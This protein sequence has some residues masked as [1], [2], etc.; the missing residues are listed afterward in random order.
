MLVP[1]R[2]A[3]RLGVGLVSRES[4][5]NGGGSD[6]G[7]CVLNIPVFGGSAGG[8][9]ESGASGGGGGSIAV[10]GP[11]AGGGGSGIGGIGANPPVYRSQIACASS[12]LIVTSRISS[13]L[14]ALT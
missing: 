14:L 8:A 2:G 6:A 13:I 10:G 9:A 3:V 11:S 7:G 5:A 4:G 1:T 12:S